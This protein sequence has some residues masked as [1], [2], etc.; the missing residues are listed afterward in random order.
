MP[1]KIALLTVYP[2]NRAPG[3][4]YRIEQY[5]SFL[6]QAG[7]ELHWV[8]FFSPAQYEAFLNPH[9]P[10]YRKAF[11][12][13][14]AFGR[15]TWRAFLRG[16]WD[17]VYLYREATLLGIPWIE[18]L[19]MRG[20]PVLM[21]FDDAIWMVDTS[22]QYRRFAWLKSSHK[23]AAILRRVRLATVCNDFL[24]QYA[25]QYAKEV[26]IIPTTVDTDAY[27]PASPSEKKQSITIGWTGSHT[28]VAHLRT[29]ERALQRLYE[30]YKE[31]IRF[32]FIGATGYQP[33]FPAEILPWRAE[34]EVSDLHPI[35]IGI[36]PLPDTLWS[37]GK[38][39]FKALQYM[40]LEI[41]PV[42]SPVG[43]NQEVIREGINGLFASGEEE[44]V[45]KLSFLIENPAERR[46]LG[47]AARETVIAKYSV[48]ANRSRYLEAFRAAFG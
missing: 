32:R 8:S 33:P 5:L 37:R 12:M 43:M 44:W 22:E 40:A 20:L 42:V 38:C 25:R 41:P 48:I 16:K 18:Y 13:S 45:E 28:T 47:A 14:G 46:R 3:L 26:H 24:A 29:V 17:G 21:D 4:R 10:L 7:Y 6:A 11:M 23:T 19:W 39:A 27:Q 15:M 9:L 1:K 34:S 36:M 2:P 30:R 35:D 31:R